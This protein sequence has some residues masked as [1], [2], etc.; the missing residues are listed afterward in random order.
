MQKN[1]LKSLKE[2]MGKKLKTSGN[3]NQKKKKRSL[4]KNYQGN[5]WPNQYMDGEEKGTKGKER[6][7]RKKIGIGGKVPWD[8]KP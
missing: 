6:G 3:R 5:L 7:D 2:S 8:K 1:Q 4:V